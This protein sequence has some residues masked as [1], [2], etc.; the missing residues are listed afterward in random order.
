MLIE[1]FLDSD[2]LVDLLLCEDKP[3]SDSPDEL[4]SESWLD[5]LSSESVSELEVVTLR[6]VSSVFETSNSTFS[7]NYVSSTPNLA[8]KPTFIVKFPVFDLAL[9]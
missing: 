5:L 1:S 6:G 7:D 3:F 8:L 9:D 4:F 2:L